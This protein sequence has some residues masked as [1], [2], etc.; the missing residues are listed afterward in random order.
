MPSMDF[1]ISTTKGPEGKGGER[2][3]SQQQRGDQKHP[4]PSYPSWLWAWIT[5]PE[6]AKGT[7]EESWA[8]VV[9]CTQD[10]FSSGVVKRQT[11]RQL[12]FKEEF[13]TTSFQEWGRP[14]HTGPHGK[15]PG[16]SGGR[17]SK[18]ETWASL[19]CGFLR[20]GKECRVNSQ[21]WLR[22]IISAGS[23]V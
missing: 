10:L 3:F 21:D 22:W 2:G 1:S 19:Y 18:G 8:H 20:K 9:K 12:L 16:Q 6:A 17:R 11:W 4:R 14:H 13:T 23:R 15:A 5:R 7:P